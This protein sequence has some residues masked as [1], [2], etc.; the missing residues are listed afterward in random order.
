MLDSES[1]AER[2]AA[3]NAGTTEAVATNGAGSR[4]AAPSRRWVRYAWAAGIVYVIALV[5]EIVV[6]AGVGLTANDSAAKIASGLPEH[7]TRLLVITYLSAVYA[8]AFLIYLSS[9]YNLLRGDTDR[10]RMLGSLVL[11]GGVLFIT[12]HAVSD[13][14]ITGLVGA[15]LASFGSQHDPGISYMLYLM[16]YALES[17]ETCS[18]VSV[19]SQQAC[20]CW[21]AASYRAG[22]GGFRS[23][24]GSCSSFRPSA[25]AA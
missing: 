25:W 10:P 20:S 17:V 21:G 15:K 6:A 14:G 5:A 12:L 16:T 2:S 11:V 22:L 3:T 4:E 1:Q 8:I 18:A 9:L 19:F 24:P 13:V 23:S 7:H